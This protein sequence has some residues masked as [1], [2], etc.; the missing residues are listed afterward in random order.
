MYSSLAL[1]L[2]P[3]YAPFAVAFVVMIGIGLIEAVGL[4]LGHL[5]LDPAVDAAHDADVGGNSLLDWLGL[6][7]VPIL[8]WL[9]S[10][11]ACFTIIGLALQQVATL[12]L[13]APLSPWLAAGAATVGG[14]LLNSL[15]ASGL[16]R[17]IPGFESSAISSDDLVRLRG[18]ILDG[19]ARRGHPARAKVVDRFGQAHYVMVEPHDDDGVI[20]KGESA[21][22]V[23]RDGSTY[24]GVADVSALH[25]L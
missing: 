5:D 1:L 8:V 18:T 23:R 21:L 12:T 22:L 16:A 14:L 7:D 9:T 19:S 20:A 10:L 17:I 25:A 6:G 13:G 3:P 24:F 15:V 11:L 2:T 4:G